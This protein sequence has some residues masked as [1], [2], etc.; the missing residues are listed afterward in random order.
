MSLYRDCARSEGKDR[1]QNYL[2]NKDITNQSADH[3][4]MG[5]NLEEN[6]VVNYLMSLNEDERRAGVES[7]LSL[8]LISRDEKGLKDTF[9]NCIIFPCFDNLKRLIGFSAHTLNKEISNVVFRNSS[10][11][12]IFDRRNYLF[13]EFVL[14]NSPDGAPMIIVEGMSDVIHI[15]QAGFDNVVGVLRVNLSRECLRK[16]E[17]Y[18][19]PIVLIF[20]N[21]EAGHRAERSLVSLLAEREFYIFDLFDQKDPEHFIKKYGQQA[22]YRQIKDFLKK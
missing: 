12:I 1:F 19:G 2:S 18:K 11:S 21:D 6:L 7:A 17:C 5:L 3:F 15:H 10:Q 8:G 14:D 22:F 16:I 20:D 4:K 9:K 13:N